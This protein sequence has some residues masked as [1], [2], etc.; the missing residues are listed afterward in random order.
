MNRKKNCSPIVALEGYPPQLYL[1]LASSQQAKSEVSPYLQI[2]SAPL[3][4]RINPKENR[5]ILLIL[6]AN[7]RATAGQ[8]TSNEAFEIARLTKGWDW[9]LDE[10]DRPKCLP[11][12][13]Q[14]L[15]QICKKST[16][17]GGEG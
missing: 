1:N 13:E 12:L 10:R 4:E 7:V 16:A 17:K 15:D 9:R 6:P 3:A 14:L 2:A 8:Y 11:R 5:Y